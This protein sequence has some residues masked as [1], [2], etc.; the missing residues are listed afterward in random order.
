MRA[1]PYSVT[2]GLV[3][4]STY[5]PAETVPAALTKIYSPKSRPPC[6]RPNLSIRLWCIDNTVKLI[7]EMNH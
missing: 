1:V 2:L 5:N 3:R 7:E 6:S 4:R